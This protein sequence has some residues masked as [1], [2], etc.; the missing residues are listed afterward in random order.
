MIVKDDVPISPL[1]KRIFC[2]TYGVEDD[3]LYNNAELRETIRGAVKSLRTSYQNNVYVTDYGAEE[4]R[5]AYMIAYY[6]YYIEPAR[7]VVENF[8]AP[9]ISPR[10][11]IKANFFASGPC[12]ELLGTVAALKKMERCIQVDVQTYDPQPGWFP[13]QQ[14]TFKLAEKLL[15]VSAPAVILA[16][17]EG[18]IET[19]IFFMQNYL[20][21][22]PCQNA[23][24]FIEDF[25]AVAART[26]SETFF[27]FVDLNYGSTA[28]VFRRLVDE[29]FL[30]ANRLAII[31]AHIPKFG[32]PLTIHHEET[33]AAINDNIF[34]G[35]YGLQKRFLT[36]FYFVVLRKGA[37]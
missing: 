36:K 21:H 27:V 22:M 15:K 35:E 24:K 25:S 1:V 20:S 32:D 18:R 6:P 3:E 12:P 2:E 28:M 19:D 5:K 17:V 11:I 29:N 8:V 31:D 10:E 33:T 30:R 37:F 26:N 14:M 7:Y 34:T 23:D 4:N 16:H 9:Q 13:Y